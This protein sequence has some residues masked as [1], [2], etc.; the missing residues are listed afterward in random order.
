MASAG[1]RTRKKGPL[2]AYI[3]GSSNSSKGKSNPRVQSGPLRHAPAAKSSRYSPV[4]GRR[5]TTSTT[6]EN[7]PSVTHKGKD[8][9][10]C[11]GIQ[12]HILK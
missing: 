6:S 2:D 3:E 7:A 10:F 4:S 12:C 5:E 9:P 8:Q 1:S 11:C